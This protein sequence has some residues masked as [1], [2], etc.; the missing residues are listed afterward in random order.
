MTNQGNV[1]ISDVISMASK[2]KDFAIHLATSPKEA[3]L[4]VGVELTPNA[5]SALETMTA[6][7]RALR[8]QTN[9]LG[10]C[11]VSGYSCDD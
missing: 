11:S 5:I 2:D 1:S 3:L 7:K 6:E 10:S 8:L 4:S 9:M